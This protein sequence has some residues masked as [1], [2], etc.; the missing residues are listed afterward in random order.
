[1]KIFLRILG[2]AA[3]SFALFFFGIVLA[4]VIYPTEDP[5]DWYAYA[6]CIAPLLVFIFL[7]SKTLRS[8]KEKDPVATTSPVPEHALQ[9]SK[10]N[11]S[12]SS[13][14]PPTYIQ[15]DTSPNS[16]LK[17]DNADLNLDSQTVYPQHEEKIDYS[18]ISI[19]ASGP[20]QIVTG[21]Y[22][23]FARFSLQEATR[24]KNVLDSVKRNYPPEYY[25]VGLAENSF[26]VLYKPRSVLNAIVTR[27][28]HDSTIPLDCL[29]T[30]LAYSTR[31]AAFR[32]QSIEHFERA[33][34]YMD[35]H[36][37]GL[38]RIISPETI[39]FTFAK[40][41]E[42]EHEYQTAFTLLT[43]GCMYLEPEDKENLNGWF[44]E[45]SKKIANPPRRRRWSPPE[46]QVQ[47]EKQVEK[48][49]EYF[50]SLYWNT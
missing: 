40:Q 39:Y 22:Y 44:G 4:A 24:I 50:I 42:K 29:S 26:G 49:A 1:M 45:L 41:Y 11:A 37:L 6:V 18:G 48:A 2:A 13:S 25:T 3:I 10:N 46:D 16:L 8:R 47:R 33:Y 20:D 14:L 36:L 30:A 38:F 12:P 17:N 21:G 15:H 7:F 43:F 27:L 28:Y 34:P 9:V 32:K 31:G 19:I 35:S 5:P 23:D